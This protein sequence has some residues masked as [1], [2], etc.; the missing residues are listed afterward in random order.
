[1]L[2]CLPK[3]S[4]RIFPTNYANMH[5]SFDHVRK[6]AA[7]VLQN[8]RLSKV[9]LTEKKPLRHKRVENTM[10]YISMIQF[11]E[12]EFEVNTATTVEEAKRALS[13]GYNYITEKEGIML[14]R[15]PKRFCGINAKMGV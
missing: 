12:D 7:R 4:E 9:S 11:E 2:N 6:R 14:F 3:T 13:V 5:A 10:K 1:M 15:R 8:P